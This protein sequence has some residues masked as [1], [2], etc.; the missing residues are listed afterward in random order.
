MKKFI[1]CMFTFLMAFVLIGCGQKVADAEDYTIDKEVEITQELSFEEAKAEV[2]ELE[3]ADSKYLT[4]EMVLKAEGMNI[5]TKAVLVEEKE[6]INGSMVMKM[7]M[8][9]FNMNYDMYIKENYILVEIP[10]AGKIKVKIPTTD[11]LGK[12][13][14]TSDADLKG[15]LDE[16]YQLA[17]EHSDSV[18]AGYDKNGCLVLDYSYED[19]KCRVVFDKEFPVYIYVANGEKEVVEIKFSYSKVKVEYPEDLDMEAY[20]EMSWDDFIGMN[21]K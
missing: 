2:K 5:T 10:M 4:Y 17:Q 11:D 16:F 9:G 15:Y 8:G 19:V 18:K 6:T 1:T 7:N 12:L 21:G 20:K 14:G 3:E 13:N